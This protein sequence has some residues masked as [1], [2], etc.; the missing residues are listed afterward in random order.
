M[1][2]VSKEDLDWFTDIRPLVA[3]GDLRALS[4]AD[5]HR[6]RTLSTTLGQRLETT[7]VKPLLLHHL[8]HSCTQFGSFC[9]VA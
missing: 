4:V 6:Y 7:F 3:S 2:S 8:P 9:G 1:M 5:L